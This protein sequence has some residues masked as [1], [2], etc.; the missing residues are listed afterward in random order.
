LFCRTLATGA[1]LVRQRGLGFLFIFG[2][3]GSLGSH[4][5]MEQ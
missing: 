3:S 5:N 1:D 2:F 4:R